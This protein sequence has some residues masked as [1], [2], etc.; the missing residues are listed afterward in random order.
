MSYLYLL[1]RALQ[2]YIPKPNIQHYGKSTIRQ[3]AKPQFDLH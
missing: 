2:I 3:H 1:A